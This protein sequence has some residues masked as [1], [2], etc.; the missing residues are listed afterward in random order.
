LVSAGHCGG[1]ALWRKHASAE[2]AVWRGNAHSTPVLQQSALPPAERRADD[3]PH[4]GN[5]RQE[6]RR[7]LQGPQV[8]IKK[9]KKKNQKTKT[10]EKRRKPTL[11]LFFFVWEMAKIKL[12][13]D[14][15]AEPIW[16]V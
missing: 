13:I 16:K 4:A 10:K 8:K 2:L 12:K 15:G 1:L 14:G 11:L 6:G 3:E 5:L 7:R 9:Q